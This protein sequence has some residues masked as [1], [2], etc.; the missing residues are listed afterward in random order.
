MM[1]SYGNIFDDI[2]VSKDYGV[3]FSDII[4]HFNL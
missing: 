4:K 2:Q 1:G 3:A